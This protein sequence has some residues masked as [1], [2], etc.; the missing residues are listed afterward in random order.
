MLKDVGHLIEAL[1][2][3]AGRKCDCA[4]A[5]KEKPPCS[6]QRAKDALNEHGR[7]FALARR[8]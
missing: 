5:A 4:K 7:K 6:H 8:R 3:I 1:K 2:Y